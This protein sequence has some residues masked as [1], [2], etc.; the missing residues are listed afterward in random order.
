MDHGFRAPCRLTV[1]T[2]AVLRTVGRVRGDPPGAWTGG[3]PFARED[4]GQKYLG[5]Q[6]LLL[7]FINLHTQTMN[8]VADHLCR[9]SRP[10]R[11]NSRL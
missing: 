11:G 7:T 6:K 8:F 5:P 10:P 4:V 3:G 9:E 1:R 2:T